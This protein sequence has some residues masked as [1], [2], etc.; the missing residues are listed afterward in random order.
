MKKRS[1]LAP[2]QRLAA[3]LEWPR[4]LLALSLLL[5]LPGCAVQS[6]LDAEHALPTFSRAPVMIL[7]K[8]DVQ[9]SE[10]TA[11]GVEQPHAQWT[12]A[13]LGNIEQALADMMR[14]RNVAMVPY[15]PPVD[16][17]ARL[18]EHQQLIKLHRAVGAS[19]IR[20]KYFQPEVL[21]TKQEAF[22]WGLGPGVQMLRDDY[23]ADYALFVFVRDSYATAGRTAVIVAM[24]VLGVGV[25]AG[26][27]AGFASLVDLR[28]GN[29]VWFSRL[30]SD[31][32]DLRTRGPAEKAVNALMRGFPL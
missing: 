8:P 6:H 11:G 27:Q 15:E 20:H 16:D 18:H 9:L 22:D 21:P 14:R 5:V 12:E 25:P 19:I 2:M 28:S 17:P 30:F 31:T 29:V 7:M 4:P 24:A 32:G 26:R 13:G 1:H 23:D 10:L 3:G